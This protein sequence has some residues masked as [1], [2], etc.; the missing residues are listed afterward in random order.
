MPRTL[1]RNFNY[2][3]VLLLFPVWTNAQV[4]IP[5]VTRIGNP[6][7]AQDAA[8]GTSVAGIG[9][10]NGDGIGDL[11]VGA[12]GLDKVSIISG[13]DQS[14]LRTVGDPDGLSKYQ[15]G[16][17]VIGVGDWDGDGVDD[18]AVSAP[19]APGVVPLPCVLP[20]C[21]VNPQWGRAFV[22]SGATGSVIKK[23]VPPGETLQFGYA[24]TPLGDIN[25]DGK[26]DLAVG[27]PMLTT[28]SAGS[29][30][31]L[32]GVDGSQIWK[33][34]ESGAALSQTQP[35]CSYTQEGGTL[36]ISA[37]SLTV[38]SV[39]SRTAVSIE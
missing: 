36:R 32:S 31:A 10:V 6:N 24:M 9:D 34:T 1:F 19:G 33:A 26:P 38:S 25:G 5:K 16:F 13:K 12:P 28:K 18:F 8:F 23:F 37:A 27:A 35:V 30:Y 20:P 14:V 3:A 4:L 21:P 15:F 11:I 39:S 2:V 22:I 17:S 29:V 7:P